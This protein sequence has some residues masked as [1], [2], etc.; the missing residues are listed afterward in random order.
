VNRLFVW[1]L[2]K[3]KRGGMST[4]MS[5]RQFDKTMD[6]IRGGGWRL[7]ARRGKGQKKYE[8]KRGEERGIA[9]RP[10][11]GVRKTGDSDTVNNCRSRNLGGGALHRKEEYLIFSPREDFQ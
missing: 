5:S 4:P 2:G 1:G 6:D 7:S 11:L 8:G 9:D 10:Y 3:R